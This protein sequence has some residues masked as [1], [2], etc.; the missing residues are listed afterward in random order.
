MPKSKGR[1][2]KKKIKS[3]FQ[4]A[5]QQKQKIWWTPLRKVLAGIVTL[6]GIVSAIVP[7]LPRMTVVSS[8]VFDVEN[9]YS[10]SFTITNTGLIPLWHLTPGIKF[11]FIKTKDQEFSANSKCDD[12]SGLLLLAHG[13]FDHTLQED[14]PYQITLSD[15]INSGIPNPIASLK[16]LSDLEGTDL[17]IVVN[18]QAWFIPMNRRMGF[19]FVAEKQYN[20]KIMWKPRPLDQ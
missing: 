2:P 9:P 7:F 11:C 3:Q 5:I 10:E 6:I 17:I 16:T 13:W 15:T 18:Y 12:L 19:R 14:E 1:R 4:Q 20:N 8:G